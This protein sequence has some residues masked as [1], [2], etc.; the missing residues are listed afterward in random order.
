MQGVFC[1]FL[2]LIMAFWSVYRPKF[3]LVLIKYSKFTKYKGI[4]SKNLFT[5][6]GYGRGGGI[7]FRITTKDCIFEVFSMFPKSSEILKD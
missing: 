1:H 3:V 6:G 2:A 5:R 7:C 4:S